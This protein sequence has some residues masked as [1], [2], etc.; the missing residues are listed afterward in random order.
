M[1]LKVENVV[2]TITKLQQ[3]VWDSFVRQVMAQGIRAG[4]L[5]ENDIKHLVREYGFT[6]TFAGLDKYYPNTDELTND[7]Q[8][9]VR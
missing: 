3:S 4:E 5:R 8:N 1:K 2:K 6:G 9:E 7:L